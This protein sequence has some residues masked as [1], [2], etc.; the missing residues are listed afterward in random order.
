MRPFAITLAT[1]AA[2]ALAAQAGP[3]LAAHGSAGHSHVTVGVGAAF[4][5]PAASIHPV[6]RP[7]YPW[8]LY[9]HHHPYHHRYPKVYR[10]FPGH[11]P[12]VV[13]FPGHP[14]V[15]HPPVRPYPLY[16]P[17]RSFHYSGPGFHIGFG[18]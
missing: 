7:G 4:H 14:P 13:P 16:Y 10:P 9:R 15:V 6:H 17:R 1:L 2:V 3:A 5:G 12:V 18:Y 11:P 8:T